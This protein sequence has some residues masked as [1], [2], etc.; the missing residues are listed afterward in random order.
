MATSQTTSLPM[1]LAGCTYDGSGGNDLRN[2]G[3]TA[4]F[5]DPGIVTGSTIGLRSGV[6]G[7]AGLVVT[8]GTG[9]NVLVQPG[10]FV[11]ANTASA[12]AGGYASTLPSQATLAVATADPTNPRLD[13]I[14]AY[15]SDSGTSASFG[16]VEII[17]GA[18]APSP[19]VPSAPANS[20]TLAQLSVPA[21]TTSITSGLLADLRPFTTTTGGILRASKGSVTGYTGQLAYDPPS[22]SFY[23]NNNT[24]NATQM[25]VLPWAPMLTTRSASFTWGGT[26][27][28]VLSVPVT[29]DG[30]TDIEIFFK[31]PGVY[32]THGSAFSFNVVFR[33]YIDSTQVDAYF[34][35]NDIADGNAHSGGS[36]SYYTSGT[37]GDTPSAG[38]HTVK[39]T[40]QNLS[41]TY[42]TGIYGLSNNK[43]ILR[44]KPA[45]L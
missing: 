29:C 28:T 25:R 20:I 31:W 44:V 1:W 26:E 6:V 5:F 32:S 37:T 36:W 7:G 39:V 17:T 41:G 22:S 35:P 24:S 21:T 43:Q 19:S 11:V 13:I 23:H 12:V 2:S 16:A 40:C 9:M 34:T 33:M 14:V 42:T 3:I 27:T 10:S 8:P 30:Y 15:V 18:A 38:A 4:F 45:S